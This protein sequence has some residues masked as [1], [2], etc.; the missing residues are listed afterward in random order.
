ML[1]TRA[2]G[3]KTL[4]IACARELKLPARAREANSR[5]RRPPRVFLA[6]LPDRAGFATLLEVH[7]RNLALATW[8]AKVAGSGVVTMVSM[9]SARPAIR[10]ARPMAVIDVGPTGIRLLIA[11]TTASEDGLSIVAD[12]AV[13][14]RLPTEASGT[15]SSV[16]TWLERGIAIIDH[17]VAF[18]RRHAAEPILLSLTGASRATAAGSA[19]RGRVAAMPG[20]TL[21]IIDQQREA[22]LALAAAFPGM[23]TPGTVLLGDLT[24]GGFA[25]LAMRDGELAQGHYLPLWPGRLAERYIASDPPLRTAIALVEQHARGLLLALTPPLPPVDRFVIVGEVARGALQ[26]APKPGGNQTLSLRRL[27]AAVAQITSL[28]A[29]DLATETGLAA[30]RIK[31]LGAGIAIAGA[32]LAAFGLDSADV[33]QGGL[34]EGLILDFVRYRRRLAR[35]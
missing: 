18:A 33:G 5:I 6:R 23:S 4:G 14:L 31:S 32:A 13:A 28:A 12:H 11:R 3:P 7:R 35:R 20:V 19:L 15:S 27:N 16:A 25:L 2:G 1:P 26:L 8:P 34:R 24:D 22:E 10:G 17:F 30:D 21:A 9:L 29:A